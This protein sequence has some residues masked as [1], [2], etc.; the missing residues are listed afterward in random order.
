MLETMDTV[1]QIMPKQ[2]ESVI[3]NIMWARLLCWYS[4][5]LQAGRSGDRIPVGV[6]IFRTCPDWLWGPHSL[7][8]NG[9]RVFPRGK[10]RAGLDA[11]P[12]PPSSAPMGRTACTEPQC[13]YKGAL[14]TIRNIMPC[15]LYLSLVHTVLTLRRLMSYIYGAPILDVS[16]SHTTTQH[17]R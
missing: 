6:E 7:L 13:L 3:H 16:R 9:Y 2:N 14:F 4:D 15:N 17:S 12:S 8:Y 10:E 11:G 1:F 5:W